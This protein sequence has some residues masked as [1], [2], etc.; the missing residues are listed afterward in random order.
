MLHY[1]LI[2]IED[3]RQTL[4]ATEI[5]PLDVQLEIAEYDV[6]AE[7]LAEYFQIHFGQKTYKNLVRTEQEWL[8]EKHTER[9][10]KYAEEVIKAITSADY[11]ILTY[12]DGI[13]EEVLNEDENTVLTCNNE[14][15]IN[16]KRNDVGYSVDVYNQRKQ[17]EDG[18][19]GSV[20]V[21]DDDLTDDED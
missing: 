4:E 7:Q 17:N 13:I 21:F 8:E 11:F 2:P 14:L 20:T 15:L 5:L 19:F 12:N 18:L 16:V 3:E 10:V 6:T 1:L 9:E